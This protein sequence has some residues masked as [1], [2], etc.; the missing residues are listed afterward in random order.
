VGRCRG[1]PERGGWIN[2]S[3]C[4]GAARVRQ[5][6]QRT[7]RLVLLGP[8]GSGKGTQAA[9][10]AEHLGACP[11]STGAVFR[12]AQSL[13][14]R[15]QSPAL[16]EALAH[17]RRGELV[18]DETVMCLVR[19]RLACLRCSGGFLLDGCPRTLAQ[20]VSLDRLLAEQRMTL[21]AVL[22]YELPIGEIVLRLSGRRTC[23]ACGAIFHVTAR[24]PRRPD[25]CD[26]CGGRLAQRDDDRADAIRARMDAYRAATAPLLDYYERRRVLL[27]V[28]GLGDPEEICARARQALRTK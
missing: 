1:S 14:V 15:D 18:P 4:A 9:L 27:R 7:W 11:L 8:P 3:L 25:L 23:G 20:A 21:D 22:R 24:P 5:A 16:Q 6:G 13:P 17:M 10:L 12:A 28:S 2:A 19:E 26:Q